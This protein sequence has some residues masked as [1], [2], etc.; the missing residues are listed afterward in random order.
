[1]LCKYILNTFSNA[2]NVVAEKE[3]ANENMLQTAF[4]TQYPLRL[5]LAEDNPFNQAV[6]TAI[7]NKLGYQFDMAENGE[8][9]LQMLEQKPYDVIL[10]DVQMPEMDG[11]EAT[12]IIRKNIT[13]PQPVIIAMTANAMQEDKEECLQAGMNDYL[14]KPVNPDDLA[15]VLKKWAEKA[16]NAQRA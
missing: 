13:W 3:A 1:V 9:A 10:M 16:V 4:A 2:V 5:L 8:Q 15:Q 14:S 11:L 7:L 6:A 12:R